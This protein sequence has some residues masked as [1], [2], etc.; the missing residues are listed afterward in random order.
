MRRAVAAVAVVA[1]LGGLA[2]ACS[3]GD[4]DGP[5]E[6]HVTLDGSPRVPDVEGVVEAMAEDLSTL[7]LDGDRTYEIPKDVQSFSTV[8]GSTQPL[9][10]RLNQYVHLGVD[11][12]TVRWIAGIATVVDN[13]GSGGGKVVYYVGELRKATGERLEFADGT[14]LRLQAGADVPAEAEGK[15]VLATI[16]PAKRVVVGLAPQ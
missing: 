5:P 11:G 8:D 2:G 16:D 10:R 9:R 1:A 14:V 6:G 13:T 12:R 3:G 4:D 7:T 15:Q